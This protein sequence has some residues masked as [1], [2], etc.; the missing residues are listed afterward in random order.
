ML[1]RKACR[2]TEIGNYIQIAAVL[3]HSYCCLTSAITMTEWH[4]F[5]A[6]YFDD[7]KIRTLDSKTSNI[8]KV[9]SDENF[10]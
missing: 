7:I 1:L 2:K 3:P 4:L 9:Q 10:L 6:K 8:F 5:Y